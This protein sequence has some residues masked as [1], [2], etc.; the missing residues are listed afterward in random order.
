[1]TWNASADNETPAAGLTYNLRIGT[2]PGG[3]D[4]LSPM[5]GG[6]GFRRLPQL[7]NAQLGLTA[8]FNYTSGISYYW[9]AQAVDNTFAGSPF[10]PESSFKILQSP[11]VLVPINATNV[12]TGDLNGDGM[13][14]DSELNI[15]LSNY[16]P[17]SPWLYMTNVAG[18]GSTNVT[19][20]LS[21]STV[22]AFGVEY[23]TNL[24]DWFFLGP[25]TPQYKFTDTNAPA[26]PQRYYRLRWP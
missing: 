5:S 19:F 22:G 8:L 23:T 13:L 4:V 14:D 15:I 3:S 17:Y 21:N 24:V 18:L 20:A 9:S 7:G 16:W 6:N 11:P 10:S 26:A 12:V 2:T 25:A 1:M